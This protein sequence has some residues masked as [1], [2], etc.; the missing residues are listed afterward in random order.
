LTIDE[1]LTTCALQIMI[2]VAAGVEFAQ[3][4][5]GNTENWAGLVLLLANC[6]GSFMIAV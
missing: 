4:I 1:T 3:A 2:W 6:V 5:T